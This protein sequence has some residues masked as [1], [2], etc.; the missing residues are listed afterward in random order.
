M[1]LP[2]STNM[3]GPPRRAVR[4]ARTVSLTCRDMWGVVETWWQ[5]ATSC[6][7]RADLICHSL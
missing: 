2:L 7:A 5:L 3:S 6:H 1:R 4:G